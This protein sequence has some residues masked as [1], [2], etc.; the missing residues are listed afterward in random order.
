MV[1]LCRCSVSV[2]LMV[3]IGCDSGFMLEVLMVFICFIRVK[4]LLSLFRVVLVWVLVSF[5]WDRLVM[6]LML[7]RVRDMVERMCWVCC[8]M[9]KLEDL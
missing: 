3:V 7:E 6:C 1:F 4:M 5:S 2:G 9:L 8:V